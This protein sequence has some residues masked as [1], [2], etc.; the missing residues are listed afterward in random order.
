M[1]RE[2]V[3]GIATRIVGVVAI[4]SAVGM[5]GMYALAHREYMVL[6]ESTMAREHDASTE[7]HRIIEEDLNET[8]IAIATLVSSV[9]P[10]RLPTAVI[11]RLFSVEGNVDIDGYSCEYGKDGAVTLSIRGT[12]PSQIALV[13]FS[14]RLEQVGFLGAHI[15]VS[16]F[17]EDADIPFSFSVTY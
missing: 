6:R 17:V 13:D 2:R 9:T 3:Y 8:K 10:E 15:P 7:E 5:F 1:Y 14:L 16:H 4:A 12:A 11:E